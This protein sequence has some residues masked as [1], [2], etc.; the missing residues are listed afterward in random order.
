M[1]C[2]AYDPKTM[3]VVF[4]VADMISGT[5]T[6]IYGVGRHDGTKPATDEI[7][8]IVKNMLSTAKTSRGGFHD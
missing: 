2:E 7:V 8:A 1:R 6:P 4:F 3:T 5:K